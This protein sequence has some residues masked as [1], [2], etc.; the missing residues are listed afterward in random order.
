M[1]ESAETM[2]TD[3]VATTLRQVQARRVRWPNRTYAD[4][5][6]V[7][8]ILRIGLVVVTAATLLSAVFLASVHIGDRYNINHVSGTWMAL[9]WDVRDGVLYRPFFEDGYYGVS[10]YMPLQFVFSAGASLV[11][12]EYLVSGKLLAYAS[13]L[14]VIALMLLVLRWAR[15]PTLLSLGLV[16]AVVSTDAGLLAMTSIHGDSLPLALQLGAVAAVIRSTSRRALV[17]AGVLCTLAVMSKFTAIWALLA[18]ALWLLAKER[19]KLV[20]FLG[21]FVVSTAAMLTF[22]EIASR[23]RLSENFAEVFTTGG[24]ASEGSIAAGVSTYFDLVTDHAGAVWLL[25]PFA[26]LAVLQGVARRSFTLVQVALLCAVPV[27]VVVLG[28]PGSDFNHLVDVGVL[29]ALVVGEQVARSPRPVDAASS[30]LR[31]LICVAVILGVAESYRVS[32]KSEVAHAAKVLAGREAS[33]HSVG[34]L[35]RLVADG[36]SVLSE[37]PAIPV[38]RGER[39]I[40][41]DGVGLR[42][43]EERHPELLTDL[44]GRLMK[45][46]FDRVVLVHPVENRAWYREMSMGATVRRAIA[47]SYALLDVVPVSLSESYWVYEPKAGRRARAAAAGAANE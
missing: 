42:R 13:G 22:F 10:A 47:D 14:A 45:Q 29:V 11:T 16:A 25:A 3:N 1:S 38:L 34:V 23:G 12:G 9:A 27:V 43:M 19:R 7:D 31:T 15:C 21:F 41:L 20:P 24:S 4:D 28:N 6:A 46:E 8:M 5:R 39:P 26:V 40:V 33:L 17:L 44:V 30:V 37:D 36:Q 35:E 2:S 18:I 32:M